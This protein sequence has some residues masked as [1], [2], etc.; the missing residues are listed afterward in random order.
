MWANT[1]VTLQAVWPAVIG[2]GQNVPVLQPLSEVHMRT[3]DTVVKRPLSSTSCGNFRMFKISHSEFGTMGMHRWMGAYTDEFLTIVTEAVV[4]SVYKVV[5]WQSSSVTWPHK[6]SG[7][8]WTVQLMPLIGLL[9][10]TKKKQKN[11]WVEVNG[12]FSWCPS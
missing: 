1:P 5:T 9:I 4:H 8:K 3:C 6:V 10:A 7:S 12:R 11:G 2:I